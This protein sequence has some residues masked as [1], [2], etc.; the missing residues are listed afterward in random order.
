M[1]ITKYPNI[2]KTKNNDL[3]KSFKIALRKHFETWWTKQAIP[4]GTNKLDFFYRYK[5]CFLYESYLD[6]L[7]RHLRTDI[8]KFRISNHCL[9]IETQRYRKKHID[10]LE[11]KCDI[12]N[13]D[14]CGDELHYLLQCTNSE[15]SHSREEF[16]KQVTGLNSQFNMF[17]TGNI[18]D[19]CMTMTDPD[20]QGPIAKF[21]K[22]IFITFREESQ[23]RNETKNVD[24]PVKTRSG[25]LVKKPA[26]LNL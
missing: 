5:K 21:V 4:T 11:R 17:T 25:R 19:Y 1:K 22:I 9:P 14:E 16:M 24:V 10:R 15:I 18:V 13:F 6:N 3:I 12:C 8:T 26:K 20:I 2:D 7:P 23:S